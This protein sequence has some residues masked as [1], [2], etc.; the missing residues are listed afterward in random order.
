MIV[1]WG[2]YPLCLAARLL[3]LAA[4][5]LTLVGCDPADAPGDAGAAEASPLRAA[6]IVTSTSLPLPAAVTNAC[7]APWSVHLLTYD[8]GEGTR[9]RE[10]YFAACTPEAGTPRL[11]ASLTTATSDTAQT[12]GLL[13]EAELDTTSGEL[14]PTGI[15]REFPE[16]SELHGVAVRSDCSMVSVLCLRASRSSEVDPLTK[17]LVASLPDEGEGGARWW[18][19][20][21]GSEAEGQVNGEEWL[22]EWPDGD[23]AAEPTRYVVD[24]AIGGWNYGRQALLYAEAQDTYAASLKATVFGG[25]AWHQGDSMLVVD[26]SDWTLDMQRGWLWACAAGHTIFNHAAFN[27]TTGKYAVGCGTDLPP[28]GEMGAYGGVWAHLEGR[29]ST[30]ILT[31]PATGI[32]NGGG[33]GTLLPLDDGGFLGVLVGPS[34]G[35]FG[36]DQ[37]FTAEGPHSSIAIARLDADGA[38]VG[39]PKWVAAPDDRWLSFPQLAPLGDGVFLLGYGTMSSVDALDDWGLLRT[40]ATYHLQE[41]DIDG[42][43]LTEAQTLAPGVGWGEQDEWVSLGRGR[44]GWA[45][46]PEPTREGTTQPP[47]AHSVLATHVYQATRDP[48]GGSDG[49]SD[50]GSDGGAEGHADAGSEV[51]TA[52]PS[53]ATAASADTSDATGDAAADGE[54]NPGC[55]CVAGAARTSGHLASWS[56][57]CGFGLHRRRRGAGRRAI[58]RSGPWAI[59]RR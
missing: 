52:G 6:G 18:L 42:N 12:A 35:G 36:A 9:P 53:D 1:P 29:E 46:T 10:M 26:R 13:L 8:P 44:V 25:G 11:W 34:D 7:E 17:D 56:L 50:G 55:G 45:Y 41:I 40:P 57:L 32:Q 22:Y 19:T 54:A 2:L 15:T 38:L 20:Q 21:P 24:K 43:A 3:P 48:G 28:F 58:H 37:D 14:L 39:E 30:G 59:H 4:T 23:L 27:G 49:A 51:T 47:C 16:C 5:G 33:A 31:L